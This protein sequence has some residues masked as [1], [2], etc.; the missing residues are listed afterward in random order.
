MRVPSLRYEILADD[1]TAKGLNSAKGNVSGFEKGIASL[2]KKIGAVF[3]ADQILKFGEAA[4]KAFTEDQAAAAKLAKTVDNLGLGFANPEIAKFIDKLTLATGIADNELRPALQKL[5]TT[6]G[7]VT[8]SQ[9][10]LNQAIDISKGSGVDLGT[11]VTD[12]SNA[13]VGNTKG[14][15]KYATGLTA[16]QLK[17]K[18]FADIMVVLNKQFAGSEAAYLDTYAGKLGVIKNA[19]DEGVKAIGHG[20]VDAFSILAEGAGGDITSITDGMINL[21]NSIGDVFRGAAYYIKEFMN[22]P[23]VKKLIGIAVWIW[24]KFGK[25]IA[26]VATL[27]LSD[28]AEKAAAKGKTLRSK[29]SGTTMTAAQQALLAQKD[30][31]AKEKAAKVAAAKQDKLNKQT[32]KNKTVFD[33]EQIELV[34]ALQGKLSDDD[35]KRAEAQL[36]ILNGNNDLATKLTNEIISANDKSGALA[37][38]LSTLPD[39]KNPFEYLSAYLDMLKQKAADVAAVTSSTGSAG[40]T[41]TAPQA[42]NSTIPGAGTKDYG[43]NVIGSEIPNFTPPSVYVQIDGKTIA[44]TLMD[45][46]L[47]GNQSYVDRRTGGFN[48]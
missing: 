39:A 29:D 19:A 15:K 2:G 30:A 11:V 6:T 28:V 38:F 24:N 48:W 43:G 41:Q 33:M 14:L 35:K 36:A 8:Y 23:I 7:A 45:Q 27:G 25:Q 32:A 21:A 46:S 44:A 10:L 34:A 47:S 16:A 13:Y 1:K 18:S 26:S 37:K 42:Y 4:V 9:D 31:A 12:L 22:N 20:L 40:N 17:S 3:A 5:I